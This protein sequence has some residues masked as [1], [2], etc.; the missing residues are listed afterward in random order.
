MGGVMRGHIG[1]RHVHRQRHGRCH[2]LCTTYGTVYGQ[3]PGLAH[4][5]LHA[6]RTLPLH[7]P[8]GSVRPMSCAMGT[9]MGCVRHVGL[10]ME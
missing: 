7:V 4:G 10:T 1:C 2:G 5:M 9:P 6:R 8:Q 3:C